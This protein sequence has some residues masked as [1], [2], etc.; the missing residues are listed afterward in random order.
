MLAAGRLDVAISTTLS[1]QSAMAGLGL[2]ELD[3]SPDLARFDLHHYLHIRHKGVA[4]RIGDVIRR[5][6]DSGELEQLTAQYEAAALRDQ[7]DRP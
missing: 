6:R 5:M 3:A 1:A 7:A 4:A 2:K